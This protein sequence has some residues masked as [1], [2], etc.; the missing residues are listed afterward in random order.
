MVWTCETS[1]R[2]HILQGLAEGNSRASVTSTE[3]LMAIL[4]SLAV[5]RTGVRSMPFVSARNRNCPQ[6]DHNRLG[7]GVRIA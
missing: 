2:V 5:R 4:K 1:G 6:P 3:A 7:A